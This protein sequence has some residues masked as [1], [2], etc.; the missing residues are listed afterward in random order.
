M[1]K[2][3]DTPMEDPPLRGSWLVEEGKDFI[4]TNSQRVT[5]LLPVLPFQPPLQVGMGEILPFPV[6][7]LII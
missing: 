3:V 4:N 7:I 1:A 6:R 5:T 2:G